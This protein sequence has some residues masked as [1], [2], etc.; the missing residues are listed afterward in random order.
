MGEIG[1][2][3]DVACGCVLQCV[4]VCCSVLQCGSGVGER[5]GGEGLVVLVSAVDMARVHGSVTS[6]A[7]DWAPDVTCGG[8][9]VC[10]RVCVCVCVCVSVSLC[11]C[12]PMCGEADMQ[13][14][15]MTWDVSRSWEDATC[16]PRGP[17]LVL[18]PGSDSARGCP[19]VCVCVCMFVCVCQ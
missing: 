11:V 17:L 2:T 5:G 13:V 7:C 9:C 8:G 15:C 16:T 12:A 10:V 1:R 4:A 19:P 3:V 18:F 14:G 6:S